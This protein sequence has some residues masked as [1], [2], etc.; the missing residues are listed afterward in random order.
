MEIK[1]I[2]Q[3][4][5]DQPTTQTQEVRT[6]QL[7]HEPRGCL[8][9]FCECVRAR[10][11]LKVA[12]FRT[13]V[14]LFVLMGRR[15][16]TNKESLKVEAQTQ[17]GKAC[18]G[19]RNWVNAEGNVK[20][21]EL[22]G[23]TAILQELFRLG[24]TE[25]S[26]LGLGVRFELDDDD[27]SLWKEC[28]ME[29]HIRWRLLRRRE[30]QG[31]EKFAENFLFKEF[32]TNQMAAEF[33][34]PDPARDLPGGKACTFHSL[35]LSSDYLRNSALFDELVGSDLGV[36]RVKSV[37]ARGTALMSA[38]LAHNRIFFAEA[39]DPLGAQ[40]SVEEILA[41]LPQLDETFKCIGDLPKPDVIG[42][43]TVPLLLSSIAEK[44]SLL[45]KGEVA[46]VSML[47]VDA[48]HG[49]KTTTILID[50]G[51]VALKDGKRYYAWYDSH[52]SCLSGDISCWQ[53]K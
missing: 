41:V 21:L 33:C 44:G 22:E 35:V 47:V 27:M 15:C 5:R 48:S 31:E 29:H 36:G 51:E 6:L 24:L 46:A 52:P 2:V 9:H 37:M 50:N 19:F 4:I 45:S 34:D 1:E 28:V 13:S 39:K 16:L 40:V 38:W 49:G 53:F 23:L 10:V 7:P 18:T 3:Q 32:L 43:S 20:D 14:C 12:T 11:C 30:L 26:V 17:I 42:S 8:F 25:E